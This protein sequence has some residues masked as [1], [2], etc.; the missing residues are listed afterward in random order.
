MK[1]H[2][3]LFLL[4][5]SIVLISSCKK[6]E[7]VTPAATIVGKWEATDAAGKITVVDFQTGKPSDQNLTQKL[8]GV[9]YEFKADK[10]FT[11]TGAVTADATIDNVPISGTYALTGTEVK[12]SYKKDGKDTF[13]YFTLNTLA[14][15]NMTWTTNKDL[16]IKGLTES[17][18]PNIALVAIL[19]SALD[20]KINFKKI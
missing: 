5:F 18:E 12:L 15:S 10:T 13:E 11:A 4:L 16:L 1:K 2:Y 8:T 3:N 9:T 6:D 14:T 20:L 19:V 7:P 17:K